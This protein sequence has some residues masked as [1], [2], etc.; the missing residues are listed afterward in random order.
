ME[1]PYWKHKGSIYNPGDDVARVG[2]ASGRPKLQL[3]SSI[4]VHIIVLPPAAILSLSDLKFKI[5]GRGCKSE[6][7]KR[8]LC[9]VSRLYCGLK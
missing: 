4:A 6:P 9:D 1:M 2:M 3:H 5:A 7:V 8:Y